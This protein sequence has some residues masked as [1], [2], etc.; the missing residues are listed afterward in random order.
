MSIPPEQ[1][2][3]LLSTKW[4]TPQKTYER[5]GTFGERSLK[6]E[7]DKRAGTAI[8]TA[9]GSDDVCVIMTLTRQEYK[10]FI[11][12]IELKT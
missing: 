2:E 4:L 3:E 1:Q 10:R 7:D 11:E 6:I 5:G 12:K 9:A 8:C